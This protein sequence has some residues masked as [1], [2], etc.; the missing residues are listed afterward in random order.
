MSG[1]RGSREAACGCVE[2][3][4]VPDYGIPQLL[5]RSGRRGDEEAAAVDSHGRREVHG[6]LLRRVLK[7]PTEDGVSEQVLWRGGDIL[8]EMGFPCRLRGKEDFDGPSIFGFA[9]E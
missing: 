4:D 3:T 6:L 8:L 5:M 7:S 2:E 9:V 1:A